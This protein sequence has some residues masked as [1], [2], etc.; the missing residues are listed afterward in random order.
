MARG[1]IADFADGVCGTLGTVPATVESVLSRAERTSPPDER[2]AEALA[3]EEFERALK[4]GASKD[5][6]ARRLDET[7]QGM[8]DD[9]VEATAAA[10]TARGAAEVVS[11]PGTID[12]ASEEVPQPEDPPP[13]AADQVCAACGAQLPSRSTKFC[14]ECGVQL[15]VR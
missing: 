7:L 8:L 12:V 3:I 10:G 6:S 9:A 15:A 4:Y 14:V 2:T 1:I 11:G 5:S 13:A